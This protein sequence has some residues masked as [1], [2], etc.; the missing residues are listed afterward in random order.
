ML[1]LSFVVGLWLHTAP[2]NS[3]F[4]LSVTECVSLHVLSI[5][6]HVMSFKIFTRLLYLYNSLHYYT[7]YF[8][9][10]R[11]LLV[12]QSPKPFRIQPQQVSDSETRE[13]RESQ[14][15]CEEG[16]KW[17]VIYFLNT[18]QSF[19]FYLVAPTTTIEDPSNVHEI[20]IHLVVIRF[21]TMASFA[22]S[23]E[24]SS[25]ITLSNL[26]PLPFTFFSNF[27]CIKECCNFLNS[28]NQ[29]LALFAFKQLLLL[30]WS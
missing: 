16:R 30:F 21:L 24:A 11:A 19:P 2:A 29:N 3:G 5:K 28:R 17:I 20:N 9:S 22:S 23:I 25:S 1:C 26:T 6:T 10:K 27:R 4:K 15:I 12:V 8:H 13:G 7:F 18:N 14:R